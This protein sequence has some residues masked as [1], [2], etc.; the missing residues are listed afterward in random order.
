[1]KLTPRLRK[2]A[3]TAHVAASVGWLGAVGAFL[4]L[5]VVALT[6]DDPETVRAA[7]LV[8]EPA[9]WLVLV[10]LALASLLSGLVQ[11][12]G[13]TWGVFRH[14]WVV[15]KLVINVFAT[16]V[17]LLYMETFSSMANVAADPRADLDAVRNASPVL[18]GAL[19]LLLLL[20]ATS[21]AVYK[22]QGVTRYGRR[23]R[24]EQRREQRERSAPAA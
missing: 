3:L 23:K 12:L 7:Y 10:P 19:A 18:H 21:L 6:S 13:T 9:A 11:S 14:Y 2:L 5:G 16:I 22:P 24:D 4:A 20:V 17:L 15:F 8:M 1:V